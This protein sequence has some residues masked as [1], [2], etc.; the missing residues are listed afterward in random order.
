MRIH[1]FYF[2]G[3]LFFLRSPIL[4]RCLSLLMNL[5]RCQ[6]G[7]CD[8]SMY[9]CVSCVAMC[10]SVMQRVAVCCSVLQCVAVCCS[11]LQCVAVCCSVLQCVAMCCSVLQCVAMCCNALQ[12]V[13]VCCS[14]LQCVALVFG[15][16]DLSIY[17]CD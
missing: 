7:E 8:L 16:Y 10:G 1:P 13:A 9:V 5:F 11:V 15:A 14:V 2:F 3:S 4:T 6:T 17:I 12:C